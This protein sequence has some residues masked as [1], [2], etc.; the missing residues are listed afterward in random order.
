MLLKSKSKNVGEMLRMKR[1]KM[2][3]ITKMSVLINK[4]LSLKKKST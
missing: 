2:S 1:K 4:K 3:S